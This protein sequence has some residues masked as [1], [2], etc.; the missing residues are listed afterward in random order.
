M[1]IQEKK[2]IEHKLRILEKSKEYKL[3]ILNKI[4]RFTNPQ[5]YYYDK[6]LDKIQREQERRKEK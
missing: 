4:K 6:L 3:F 5:Q 2:D 1:T